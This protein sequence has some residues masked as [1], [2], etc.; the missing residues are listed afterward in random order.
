MLC[1]MQLGVNHNIYTCIF[2][3]NMSLKKFFWPYVAT[4][5]TKYEWTDTLE[6]VH[7]VHRNM[8]CF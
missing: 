4:F 5:Y 3:F 6:N 7:V 8:S 2:S 1:I